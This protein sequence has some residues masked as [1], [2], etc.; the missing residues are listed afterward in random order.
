M[1]YSQLLA[2]VC[3]IG[4]VAATVETTPVEIPLNEIWALDMPGTR[5][6][7]ELDPA[8]EHEPQSVQEF[9]QSSLV[10]RT[11]QRLGAGNWPKDGEGPGRGFVVVG[12]DRE[13]L[14]QANAVLS[15]EIERADFLP[16]G[17]NLT[18][19]FY[20]YSG[21]RYVH[22]DSAERQGQTITV[23]YHFVAHRTL[24]MSTHLALIPLGK[25]PDGKMRVRMVEVEGNKLDGAPRNA[26]HVV[27][28]S[29]SFA[30]REE[31]Q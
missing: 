18:L 13:A 25:L 17:E 28:D 11:A 31:K 8:R 20:S 6:L 15:K 26:R 12:T 1:C 22:L 27:C 10:E 14:R 4:A 16:G 2:T 23:K 3:A 7:R 30:V 29:F 24:D 9:I 19:V 5:N 21:G